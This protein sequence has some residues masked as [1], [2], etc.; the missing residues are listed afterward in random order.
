M[1]FYQIPFFLARWLIVAPREMCEFR[2]KFPESSRC[3]RGCGHFRVRAS[4]SANSH[5]PGTLARLGG[6]YLRGCGTAPTHTLDSES[7]QTLE[8]DTGTQ[9]LVPAPSRGPHHRSSGRRTQH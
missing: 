4:F 8:T 1:S 3:G 7:K 9:P 6:L 5:A 2:T